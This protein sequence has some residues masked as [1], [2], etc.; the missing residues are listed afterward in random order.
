MYLSIEPNHVTPTINSP[1]S[2]LKII[3][4][5]CNSIRSQQKQALFH[6]V[7]NT[8]NPDIILASET[9]IDSTFKNAEILPQ[10]YD[11]YRKDRDIHG[12]GAM[13]A[14]KQDLI[15]EEIPLVNSNC[16]LVLAKLKVVGSPT[17]Y[18]GSY[19]R[20]PNHEQTKLLALRENVEFNRRRTSS[21]SCYRRGFQPPEYKLAN[22]II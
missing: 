2:T 5:N 19:Y 22:T 16:E 18:L 20:Q 14:F 6:S 4:V 21:K 17:L 9:H 15:L 1:A 3:I 13:I 12:G 8:E 11:A 7:I 10:S